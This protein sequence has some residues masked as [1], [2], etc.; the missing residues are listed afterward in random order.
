MVTLLQ[1]HYRKQRGKEITVSPE[2][3]TYCGGI[4]HCKATARKKHGL[5]AEIAA[6]AEVNFA[7]QRHINT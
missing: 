3:Q 6:E 7:T 1:T 4:I 2:N 5:K